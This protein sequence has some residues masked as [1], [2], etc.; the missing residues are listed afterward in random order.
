MSSYDVL[1]LAS[2]SS[3]SPLPIICFQLLNRKL[4]TCGTYLVIVN[5]IYHSLLI[6]FRENNFGDVGW[7][8][9]RLHGYSEVH[10]LIQA[11]SADLNLIQ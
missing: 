5:D 4:L 7:K 6:V 9:I 3:T 10:T 11:G 2:V 8:V 1:Y